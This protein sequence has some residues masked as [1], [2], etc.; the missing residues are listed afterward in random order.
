MN[1]LLPR[2]AP[3]AQPLLMP[4]ASAF[5]VGASINGATPQATPDRVVIRTVALSGQQAPG[6]ASGVSFFDPTF[7]T[8]FPAPPLIDERDGN[9]IAHAFLAGPGISI[10]PGTGNARS[11]WRETRVDGQ[12]VLELL[13]R[14]GDQAPGT[15]AVFEAFPSLFSAPSLAMDDG[16]T[17]FR[18]LL[19]AIP[20]GFG[21]WGNQSGANELLM[22]A[23]QPA[24]GLPG[25]FF[26]QA[27]G[28]NPNPFAAPLVNASGQTLQ[29]IFLAG[30][31]VT[32]DNDE[33]LWSDRSASLQLVLREG[34][35]APGTDAVF[36]ASPESF[37]PGGLRTFVFNDES[38]IALHGNLRGEGITFL[39]DDGIWVED[40]SGLQLV[41]L[42]G[43]PAP[44]TP[45]TFGEG[46]V[47]DTFNRPVFNNP[48]KVAFRAGL[49]PGS[50]SFSNATLWSD[51]AGS[52]SMV[53]GPGVDLPDAPPG[54]VGG[55]SFYSLTDKNAIAF[56]GGFALPAPGEV[57]PDDSGIWHDFGGQMTLA[58]KS[59]DPVPGEAAGV[60]FGSL[61]EFD[62]RDLFKLAPTGH[63][64]FRAELEGPGIT[65]G[66]NSTSYFIVSPDAQVHEV[67]RDREPF[68]LH[69]D[70]SDVRVVQDVLPG[71]MSDSGEFAFKA[72]FTDG[73]LGIFTARIRSK[74]QRLVGPPKSGPTGKPPGSGGR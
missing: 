16:H 73:T 30:Q 47:G 33:S 3:A 32:P 20:S 68:D 24:P 27:V 58:V 18:G 4:F 10:A 60:V 56:V 34:D 6:L 62:G 71:N 43:Q 59:G 54:G 21:V 41:A 37:S 70:G 14:Q 64:G 61:A 36:G 28:I 1:L 63:I 44:G 25:V 52:L 15:S 65:A 13:A 67:V 35:P 39:N 49:S 53:A 74:V 31:G 38:R 9:V 5:L 66:L 19:R 40:A 2:G 57:F 29:G 7:E 45:W 26:G 11:I 42:E 51:R 22:L 50:I 48:G 12:Q 69:G 17:A 72:L 55:A 46:G 23:G 8:A